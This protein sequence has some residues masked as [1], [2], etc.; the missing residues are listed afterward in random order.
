MTGR[1]WGE[2]ETMVEK[3]ECKVTLEVMEE[4][5][6]WEIALSPR[7]AS[8]SNYHDLVG[9]FDMGWNGRSSGNTHNSLSG[10][11]FV[12]GG[13]RTGL[14]MGLCVKCKACAACALAKKN[15]VVA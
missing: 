4:N 3:H 8:D 7:D 1:A 12:I 11:A 10:Q 6:Q 5:L 2:M 9:A 14:I 15:G 13:S